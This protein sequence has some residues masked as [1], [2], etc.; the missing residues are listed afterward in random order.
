MI[1]KRK[2]VF[3]WILLAAIGLAGCGNAADTTALIETEAP[4]TDTSAPEIP[5]VP[6]EHSP[7]NCVVPS[8]TEGKYVIMFDN[9]RLVEFNASAASKAHE[10]AAARGFKGNLTLLLSLS[11]LD[12]DSK[13]YKG[14]DIGAQAYG[15][16]LAKMLENYDSYFT[17]GETMK[18]YEIKVEETVGYTNESG[19]TCPNSPTQTYRHT[20]KIKVAEGQTFSVVNNGNKLGMRFVIAFKNGGASTTDSLID[21]SCTATVYT[22]PKGV[23][24]VIATYRAVEGDVYAKVSGDVE[25]IPALCNKVDEDTLAELMGGKYANPVPNLEASQATLK[26]GY[27]TLGENHLMNNKRLVLVCD[28]EALKE[29]QMIALGHGERAYGGSAVQITRD[30]VRAYYFASGEEESIS[31]AHG[32]DLSGRIKITIRSGFGTAKVSI[33][34]ESDKFVSGEFKWGGRNGEIFARSSGVELKNVKLTWSSTDFEKDIWLMGDSYFNMT[35]PNRWP[36]Y[37]LNDGH[38]NYLMNGFPGRNSKS[39]I[40][41]FKA[42]LEFGT[43]K[44]AVW[45]MGMNDAD[46]ANAASASWKAATD[47]FLDICDQKGIIPILTTIPNTPDRINSFKNE[48]V[49]ASGCDYIDFASAVGATEI[50]SPWIPGTLSGDG[51]HPASSGARLLYEQIKKDFPE[52]LK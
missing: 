40:A 14:T 15:K 44:Y 35:D 38:T 9:G 43:P 23:D 4:A 47:E 16:A 45:C 31:V 11:A 36:S 1:M 41:D 3:A 50:G 46:S 33:E 5:E 6:D 2:F 17:T 20:Q 19:V 32:L 37:L 42:M 48:I 51:V 7:L 10:D 18:G 29:G 30:R 34:N 24:E 13:L 49:V 21:T 25:P 28:V 52:I 27:I 8:V 22:V 12:A 39:A 26:D